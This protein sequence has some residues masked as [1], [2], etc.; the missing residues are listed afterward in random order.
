MTQKFIIRFLYSLLLTKTKKTKKVK[1]HHIIAIENTK[2]F[3]INKNTKIILYSIF[4]SNIL[5][6]LKMGASSSIQ[7]KLKGNDAAFL[8]SDYLV[9]INT[10]LDINQGWK[11]SSKIPNYPIEE[12]IN[13]FIL[14]ILGLDLNL[15]ANLVNRI[16]GYEAKTNHLNFNSLDSSKGL[17]VRMTKKNDNKRAKKGQNVDQ[18]RLVCLLGG[19]QENAVSFT[20]NEMIMKFLNK[21]FELKSYNGNNLEKLDHLDA[22]NYEELKLMIFNDKIMTERFIDEYIL[23]TCQGIVILLKEMKFKDQRYVEDILQR[24]KDRKK[25]WIIHHLPNETT[26]LGVKHFIDLRLKNLFLVK[27]TYLDLTKW[28]KVHDIQEH[29]YNKSIFVQQDVNEHASLINEDERLRVVH[30]ILAKENSVAGKCYNV[31]TYKILE[32]Y[33]KSNLDNKWTFNLV[34]TFKGFLNEKQRNYFQICKKPTEKVNEIEVKIIKKNNL[35]F[36]VPEITQKIKI[37]YFENIN[38]N[39]LGSAL[40][41]ETKDFITYQVIEKSNKLE[42]YLDIP[43]LEKKSSQIRLNQEEANFQYLEVSGLKNLKE[44]GKKEKDQE[45]SI[46]NFNE[47]LAEKGTA[48]FGAFEMKI[49]LAPHNIRFKKKIDSQYNNGIL[50]VILYKSSKSFTN[51]DIFYEKELEKVLESNFNLDKN[52]SFKHIISHMNEEDEKILEKNQNIS[53]KVDEIF[54]SDLKSSPKEEQIDVKNLEKKLED[55]A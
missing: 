11:I 36:L 20:E 34:N 6:N 10:I 29:F 2:K 31:P 28:F 3:K 55:I 19:N 45:L 35:L 40:P 43:L 12:K 47:I 9:E 8:Y 42:I 23:E 16:C 44:N 50:S 14:G 24:Y 51:I 18:N 17:K 7:N 33:I 4:E 52:S 30:L 22:R 37:N 26:I 32:E 5:N 41:L 53:T 48:Q 25:I 13:G 39:I 46:D 21:K 38:Y 1:M 15:K 27:E 54:K 49:P